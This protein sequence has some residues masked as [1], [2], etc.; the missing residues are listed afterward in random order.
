MHF[1]Y[2]K[3]RD[4]FPQAMDGVSEEEFYAALN[5]VEPSLIRTEADEFTYTFHIIIRY[6]IEKALFTG[7]AKVEDI[8]ELWNKKYEQ[9]LGITPQTD[10]E[11]VLQDV[12]W[13]SGFGYFPT[14]AIG[15]FYNAMYYNRMKEEIPVEQSIASG[16]FGPVN[17]WMTEHVFKKADLLPPGEWIRDITG[18]SFTPNDFLDYLEEKYS[19][20]YLL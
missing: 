10:R 12:H 9:Y 3:V 15:N 7:T 4:V 5:V 8:R 16:D 17:R 2:P 1:I 11:G 13:A 19:A 18:R 20:I 6:E 14:Y